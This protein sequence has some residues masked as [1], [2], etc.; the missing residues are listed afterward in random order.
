[1]LDFIKVSGAGTTETNGL[2]EEDGQFNSKPIYKNATYEIRWSGTQWQIA[3]LDSPSNYLYYGQGAEVATPDLVSTWGKNTG[4]SEPFPIVTKVS[5][6][7][8]LTIKS[9]GSPVNYIYALTDIKNGKPL[10]SRAGTYQADDKITIEWNVDQWEINGVEPYLGGVKPEYYA[11][12][13]DVETPDLAEGWETTKNGSIP[14]PTFL[15]GA[16]SAFVPT[17]SKAVKRNRG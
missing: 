13:H 10:Y 12:V 3:L 6:E 9:A 4:A 1:M 16:I 7:E 11:A 5:Y 14:Y 2:Y 17:I 8:F 15:V